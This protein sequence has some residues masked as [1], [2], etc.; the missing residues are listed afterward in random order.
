MQLG[1]IIG[2]QLASLPVLSTVLRVDLGID[3]VDRQR[4]LRVIQNWA[5]QKRPSLRPDWTKPYGTL[6]DV[7]AGYEC[8]FADDGE[9]FALS[10]EHPDT[11]LSERSWLVDATIERRESQIVVA[12]RLSVRQPK[13]SSFPAPRAPRILGELVRSTRVFDVS[14]LPD[15][16]VIYEAR[17]LESFLQLL[18][19]QSRHLPLLTIST[20]D[21]SGAT[22]VDAPRLASLLA[23]V[24]HV[25]VLSPEASW[26]LT[27]RL[28]KIYSVY[29]GAVRCYA[30]GFSTGDDPKRHRLWLAETLLRSSSD[31][32][33]FVN[34]CL[35][36]TFAQVTSTFESYTLQNPRGLR[37]RIEIVSQAASVPDSPEVVIPT[38][39]QAAS[40]ERASELQRLVE[41]LERELQEIRSQNAELTKKVEEEQT[42]RQ[43]FEE[44]NQ[45]LKER[46]A[47][48]N[49]AHLDKNQ[50][51]AIFLKALGDAALAAQI[52]LEDYKQVQ[53]RANETEELR[54]EARQLKEEAFNLKARIASL[55]NQRPS[56]SGND[57]DPTITNGD[58]ETLELFFNRKYPQ[59]FELTN[60]GCK[61]FRTYSYLHN[62]RLNSGLRL[63]RDVYIPMKL[64]TDD[65]SRSQLHRPPLRIDVW[66]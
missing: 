55:E 25:A 48:L 58:C 51:G 56:V 42:Y 59:N 4:A 62:D 14:A 61:S 17:D 8:S 35:T 64:S 13:A 29:L 20:D 57:A 16:P 47:I 46:I 18:N 23:G 44:D 34:Q 30:T 52:F 22:F 45:L 21:Q 2:D 6:R 26:G 43:L 9:N 50:P 11:Q 31:K 49:G 65:E 33:R 10:F 38:E 28:G 39:A 63:L 27:H 66:I 36:Y 15:Q 53:H 5:E 32:D 12:T 24:A 19:S 7:A 3:E 60:R 54:K 41:G 1:E 37:N 40:T